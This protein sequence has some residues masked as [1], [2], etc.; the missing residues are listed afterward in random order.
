MMKTPRD[1]TYISDLP[2]ITT[3]ESSSGGHVVQVLNN[4]VDVRQSIDTKN[5][6]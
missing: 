1:A 6:E 2:K 3:H 4:E 5:F